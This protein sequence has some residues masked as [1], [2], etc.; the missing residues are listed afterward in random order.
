MIER[1]SEE[2][3]ERVLHYLRERLGMKTT[4]IERFAFYG[5]SRGRILL[6]PEGDFDPGIADTAGVPIARARETV[7]PT[8]NL[9]QQFGHLVTR[10]IVRLRREKLKEFCAGA[11]L[12]LDP[13]EIGESTRGYVMVECDGLALGCG[14]LREN[15]LTNM[16]PKA[17][18]IDL[19]YY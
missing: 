8:I 4:E 14:L 7:K 2:T 1:C 10:N 12:T 18:R 6:V 11:D 9:F 16:V 19:R 13:D 5:T 3:R 17:N 15:E